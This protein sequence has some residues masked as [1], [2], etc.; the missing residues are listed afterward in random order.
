MKGPKK[1]Y[2]IITILVLLGLLGGA[3]YV[4]TSNNKS[5]S[6]FVAQG[7][8]S[9]TQTPTILGPDA[10]SLMKEIDA[11]KMNGDLFANKTFLKLTDITAPI[12]SESK[13][14]TNPFAPIR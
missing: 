3:F 10:L 6:V 11:L 9:D 5:K 7:Q 1:I 8:T 14:R 2:I 12:Q 13:G 4:G